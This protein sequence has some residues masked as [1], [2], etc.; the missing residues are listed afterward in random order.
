MTYETNGN[1]DK[2]HPVS[3][4]YALSL[5]KSLFWGNVLGRLEHAA[6]RIH[7]ILLHR[8]QNR[9]LADAAMPALRCAGL[10][11]QG[12]QEPAAAGKP[13]A[14]SRGM[15]PRGVTAS[16]LRGV[17]RGGQVTGQAC[18][19]L[20]INACG[21]TGGPRSDRA[22]LSKWQRRRRSAP[23]RRTNFRRSE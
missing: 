6:S 13:L 21:A 18:P 23:G 16:R 15:L 11:R 5:G 2:S 20:P 14:G 9:V 4:R 8:S 7:C 17:W 3:L 12:R 19:L 22:R 10:A 1:R